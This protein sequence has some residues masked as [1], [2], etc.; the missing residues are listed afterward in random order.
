MASYAE[1]SR[2]S[3]IHKNTIAG[4]VY[5][6]MTIEQAISFKPRQYKFVGVQRAAELSGRSAFMV[7]SRLKKGM[8]LDQALVDRY[9]QKRLDVD[10]V[11]HLV[12]VEKLS[13]YSVSYLIGC[14]RYHLPLFCR[15]NGISYDSTKPE[16]LIVMI[17][18]EPYSQNKMCKKMGWTP[19]CF[20]SWKRK[21]KLSQQEA[22]EGYREYKGAKNAEL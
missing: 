11:R 18:G 15:K 17:D 16:S 1:L 20:I 19:N 8:T 21:R 12:E 14:S 6:G 10:L 2:Q 13:L 22:F 3:G 4:R 9:Y 5:K 7:I